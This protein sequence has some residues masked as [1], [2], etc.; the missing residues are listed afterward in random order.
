MPE[1]GGGVY[2]SRWCYGSP[3]HKFGLRA[4]IWVVEVNGQAVRDLDGFLQIARGL[5]DGESVRLKTVDMT[6]KEK[7]GE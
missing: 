2:C 7:V 5:V 4:T 3:A 6:K 1:S